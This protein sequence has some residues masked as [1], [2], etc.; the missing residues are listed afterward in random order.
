MAIG[1]G[2]ER[3]I[4]RAVYG[5]E[6]HDLQS[7]IDYRHPRAP[8]LGDAAPV[9]LR[10]AAI[11][12]ISFVRRGAD[13]GNPRDEYPHMVLRIDGHMMDAIYLRVDADWR[14]RCSISMYRAVYSGGRD[15]R[16]E[17]DIAAAI[18]EAVEE[19]AKADR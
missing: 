9:A 6:M 3:N 7:A 17:R 18:A 12:E 19:R 2:S 11:L 14:D 4:V 13:W 16:V 10:D 8:K 5:I 15:A 1:D